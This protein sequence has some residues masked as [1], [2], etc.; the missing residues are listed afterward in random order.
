ML[1]CKGRGGGFV[2]NNS[3]WKDRD[4][5]IECPTLRKFVDVLRSALVHKT[6]RDQLLASN[7]CLPKLG[8]YF[9]SIVKK[10]TANPHNLSLILCRHTSD[11]E[12]FN[13][14]MTKYAPKRNAFEY[15]VSCDVIS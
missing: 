9:H 15:V 11:L 10:K 5:N 13:S 7:Y 2:E 3:C 14:M 12:H 8:T 4:L 6:C 1:S